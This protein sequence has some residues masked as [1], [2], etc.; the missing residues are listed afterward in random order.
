MSA[1]HKK[2]SDLKPEQIEI[3]AGSRWTKLPMYGAILAVIG[4]GIGFFG[5]NPGGAFAEDEHLWHAKQWTAYLNG[6]M[7]A[8]ALGFGGMAFTIIQHL[9]PHTSRL[10]GIRSPL[11]CEITIRVRSGVQPNKS[12]SCIDR[13]TTTAPA[14]S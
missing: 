4:F 8:M 3:K 7:F 12:L 11:S 10:Q 6:F 2:V 13:T 14:Y 1:H 9:V 5:P